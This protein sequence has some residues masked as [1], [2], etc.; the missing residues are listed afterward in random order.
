MKRLDRYVI[1]ELAVPLLIGT[2]IF[3]LLFVANDMIAI[4]KNF[5]VDSIPPLA[6][7][8]LLLFKFPQ[9]LSLT[10]PI[11]MT[12]GASLCIS[13]LARES[14]LTAMRAAGIPVLRVFLPVIIV[15]A[16]ISVTNFYIIERLIPPATKSYRKLINEVGIL[17][18]M[19]QFKS[20]VMLSIDRSPAFGRSH[21][22]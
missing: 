4:Y 1:K 10:L 17:A 14:E 3:A 7:V 11:G 18:A 19:P 5:N 20:N 8:Q 22:L 12:L 21:P 15:G 9:W 16:L 13:R 2:I 6:I